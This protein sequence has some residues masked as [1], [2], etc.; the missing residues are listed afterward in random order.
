MFSK[1]FFTVVLCALPA[2]AA[3]SPLISVKKTENAI[4]GRYIVTFKDDVGSSASVSSVTSQISSKSKVTHEWGIIN[5]FAGTFTDADLGLL[6]SNP[7]VAS[8]EEDGY[9]HTQTVATQ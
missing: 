7:D 3:P 1:Q 2:L 5:G 9:A 4:P 6:K 8:I